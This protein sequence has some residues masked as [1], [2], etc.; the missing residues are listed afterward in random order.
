MAANDLRRLAVKLACGGLSAP[1]IL[2]AL[3]EEGFKVPR[4]ELKQLLS[5]SAAWIIGEQQR[6]EQK[7]RTAILS[8]ELGQAL[9]KR[10][11][12][13]AARVVRCGAI[14]TSADYQILV[15]LWGQIAAQCF[16]EFVEMAE[17]RDDELFVT[18]SGGQT[19]LEMVSSLQERPR[20]NVHFYPAALIGRG[21]MPDSTH[22]GP[23]TNATIAWARSGRKR[24]H[25]NYAT[26]LPAETFGDRHLRDQSKGELRRLRLRHGEQLSRI[27]DDL[28]NLFLTDAVRKIVGDMSQVNMAIVSL[29]LVNPAENSRTGDKD[30]VSMTGLVSA[31]G[32]SPEVFA[33]DGMVGD[34]S[35]CYIDEQGQSKPGWNVFLTPGYPKQT[36][37]EFY[38]DM[39]E[40]GQPVFVCAGFQKEHLLQAALR[41]N[42]VN[43][44]ITDEHTALQLI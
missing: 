18:I 34:I 31:L 26:V 25:L 23:E 21:R 37:A 42:L 27:R 6:L 4:R 32:L 35:Y 10:Y 5:E 15:K 11:D 24:G 14:R 36:A 3:R 30:L 38:R 20:P 40:D 17:S 29:G 22:V 44:V 12:L 19:T 13:L 2:A 41:G 9:R 8:E 33:E 28:E 7:E 1:E 39:V 16:D 43:V